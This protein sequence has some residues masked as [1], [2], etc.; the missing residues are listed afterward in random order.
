[1]NPMRVI[2]SVVLAGFL[3]LTVV[4]VAQHGYVGFFELASANWATRL[5]SLDLVISLS[6][7]A[8]WMVR[9][10]RERGAAFVPYLLVTAIFGAAGPLLYLIWRKPAV[11]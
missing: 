7:I 9:D 6:L 5:L 2:L 3:A 8:A 10:A 4:A 1:M 11:V